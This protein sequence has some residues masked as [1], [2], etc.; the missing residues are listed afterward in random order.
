MRHIVWEAEQPV[1]STQ[2]PGFS[3]VQVRPLGLL[4]PILAAMVPCV[5]PVLERCNAHGGHI[6]SA[7]TRTSQ[8][9]RWPC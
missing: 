9:V 2:Q 5:R 6:N 1:C 7:P 4:L 8:R 3:G